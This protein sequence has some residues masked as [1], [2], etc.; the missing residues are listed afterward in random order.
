MNGNKDE[1]TRVPFQENS[2]LKLQVWEL[3]PWQDSSSI[4]GLANGS[5]HVWAEISTTFELILDFQPPQCTKLLRPLSVD[6]SFEIERTLFVRHVSRSNEES[7]CDPT[8]KGI[9]REETTVV[10]EDPSP[11][12]KGCKDPNGG[13]HCGDNELR[14]IAGADDIGVTPH[15]EPRKKA[16]NHGYQRVYGQLV[17]ENQAK[18]Q[19]I[20][21]RM[22]HK[23]IRYEQDPLEFVP[24]Q[25]Y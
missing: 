8:K 14:A 6:F 23:G 21:Q 2:S 25:L 12:Y 15:I 16:D 18:E 17:F 9:P 13:G 10:E 24:T 3:A 4:T 22:T 5:F 7:K 1:N 19:R 11:T 20:I